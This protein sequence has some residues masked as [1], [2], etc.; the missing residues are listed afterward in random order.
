MNKAHKVTRPGVKHLQLCKDPPYLKHGWVVL[1]ND[2][3]YWCGPSDMQDP[4][5]HLP[6]KY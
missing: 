1:S 4:L 2:I 5:H 6:P 3:R